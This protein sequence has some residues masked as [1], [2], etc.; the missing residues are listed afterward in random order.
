MPVRFVSA[1]WAA[2]RTNQSSSSSASSSGGDRAPAAAPGQGHRRLAPHLGGVRHPAARAG[3]LRRRKRGET[4]A[5]RPP[6]PAPPPWSASR[7]M[8]SATCRSYGPIGGD[9]AP[10]RMAATRTIAITQTRAGKRT[11]PVIRADLDLTGSISEIRHARTQPTRLAGTRR[12]FPHLHVGLV[13]GTLWST[14][15]RLCAIRA[16]QTASGQ[17]DRRQ[18]YASGR[19]RTDHGRRW[20]T[21]AAP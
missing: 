13:S 3:P 20:L 17:R 1:T 7:A 6:P 2:C 19:T 9:A 4:P 10:S 16:K 11:G 12:G 8:F 15:R 14:P 18:G 5:P 21:R